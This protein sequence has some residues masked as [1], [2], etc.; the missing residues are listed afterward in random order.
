MHNPPGCFFFLFETN[1]SYFLRA[2]L[3]T[4]NPQFNT[5]CF[6]YVQVFI[7]ISL[8][9]LGYFGFLKCLPALAVLFFRN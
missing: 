7:S 8:I 6:S 9:V 4:D 1:N 5:H 2:I 3:F